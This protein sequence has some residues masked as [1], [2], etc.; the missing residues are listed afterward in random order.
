MEIKYD[1]DKLAELMLYI[2]NRMSN[3][4][5]FGATVLNKTLFFSDFFQYAASGAP[6]TGADY[7]KLPQGPAP[8][9][10]L[11]VQSELVR[12]GAAVLRHVQ[13]GSYTQKRLIPLR[14]ADLSRFSGSEIGM[15]EHVIGQIAGH[16]AKAVSNAS[17][18]LVGWQVAQPNETIPY[19]SVFLF[20]APVTDAD[21]IFA[22]EA[23]GE[24]R[25]ELAAAV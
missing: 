19:H 10:L 11:P 23:E 20:S 13:R 15:V 12:S 8:R 14:D 16:D 18:T 5:Y 22:K 9:R 4:T 7:Q 17:H 2:A 21:I 6:I 24:L 25:D 3:D 1:E